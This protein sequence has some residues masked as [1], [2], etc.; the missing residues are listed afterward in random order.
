ML[1]FD[2]PL[3][4]VSHQAVLRLVY[5][6]FAGVSR[7]EAPR[8]SIPLNTVIELTPNAAGDKYFEKRTVLEPGTVSLSDG[9]QDPALAGKHD[10]PSH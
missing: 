8:L 4:I 1:H 2:E 5:A 7:E 3:L 10:P 6:Y 9:Q